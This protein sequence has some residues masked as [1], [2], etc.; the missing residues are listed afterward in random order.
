MRWD[1]PGAVEWT[2]DGP[3]PVLRLGVVHAPYARSLAVFDEHAYDLVLSG[4]THGGQLRVPR[5]GALVT[6]SDLPP[7][8]ARGTSA[9]GVDL[10][11]HVSAG[12]GHSRY[13]PIRFACRPELSVLDLLPRRVGAD[14]A[15][16][17]L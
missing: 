5:L 13:Y 2:A 11:L 16:Q 6:N 3:P 12:L 7:K 17:V 10:T 4:H 14:A 15:G 8:Q 1:R 9:W